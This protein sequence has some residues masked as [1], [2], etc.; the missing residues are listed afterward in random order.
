MTARRA[1]RHRITVEHELHCYPP[2]ARRMFLGDPAAWLPGVMT[3]H[4]A[5]TFRTHLRLSGL[6][7]DVQF[8]LGTPWTR[9]TST[10]RRLQVV[11]PDP[12]HGAGWLLPAID[13]DLNLVGEQR[14]RLRFEGATGN[15]RRLS[16]RRWMAWRVMGAVVAG[17]CARLTAT[18]P[19]PRHPTPGAAR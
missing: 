9:G 7:L 16:V 14:L 4:G 17:I 6:G 12:P 2:D 8:R 5:S 13:G 1:P 3:M 11:V 10:T 15:A 18:T 19:T